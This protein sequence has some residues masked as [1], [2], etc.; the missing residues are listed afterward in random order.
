[1]RDVFVAGIGMT[2]FGKWID[3]SMND[4]GKEA[5]DLALQDAGISVDDI[6]AA[7]VGNC[8]AGIITGQESIR[9]QVILRNAGL[10][11]IPI[12]NTEN[13]CAT[14]ATAFHLGNLLVAS[15][16][17]DIVLV[18]G[19]EKL[20]HTERQRTIDALNAANDPVALKEYIPEDSRSPF[21]D[22]YA[23][24]ARAYLEKYHVG[25]EALAAVAVKNR[26]N[27]ALNEKAQYRDTI[28]MED[29][30]N[31]TLIS[32]PLHLLMCC[33]ITDGAAATVICTKEW[34]DRLKKGR[35]L[36]KVEASSVVS[37]AMPKAGADRWSAYGRAAKEAYKTSGLSPKDIGFVEI[38]EPTAYNELSAVEMIGVLEPG[39]SGKWVLEGKTELNG[40]LPINA[41]G[42]SLSRGHAIGATGVAQLLEIT[43]QLRGEAGSR[44]IKNAEVGLAEVGGGFV[45][46]DAAAAAIH[47]LSNRA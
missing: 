42:G 34:A 35:P 47:I 25:V 26:R 23:A 18:L 9:G 29:V 40:L 17:S 13:A 31:S 7:V 10:G 24:D 14:G 2:A 12:Y 36:V 28:T 37:G 43:M 21:M 30:W 3:R 1:M 46:N 32:D 5:V 16:K 4:L 19:V 6:Q 27:A 20:Y 41:S 33:P 15:G 8:A 38:H 22:L 45:G 39:Q 11:S 44:Q